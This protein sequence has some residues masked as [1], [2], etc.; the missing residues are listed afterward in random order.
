VP[1]VHVTPEVVMDTNWHGLPAIQ[2]LLDATH[3]LPA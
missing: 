3:A 2:L 1:L